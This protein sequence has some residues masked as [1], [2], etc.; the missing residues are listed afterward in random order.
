MWSDRWPWYHHIKWRG[1]SVLINNG[2]TYVMSSWSDN[3]NAFAPLSLFIQHQ[4]NPTHLFITCI[5]LTI[6]PYSSLNPSSVPVASCWSVRF[7]IFPYSPYAF[8]LMSRCVPLYL[9]WHADMPPKRRVRQEERKREIVT[10]VRFI[11]IFLVLWVRRIVLQLDEEEEE[12]NISN[13]DQTWS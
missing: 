6:F 13:C 10:R 12:D 2:N 8:M 3:K 11:V 7:N 4:I 9:G 1:G 5:D